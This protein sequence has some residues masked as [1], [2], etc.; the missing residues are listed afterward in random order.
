MSKN[1]KG[2]IYRRSLRSNNTGQTVCNYLLDT[3]ELRGCPVDNC[4]K[5]LTE[6]DIKMAHKRLTPEQKAGIV[7][8]RFE[9]GMTVTAIAAKYGICRSTAFNVISEY[10]NHGYTLPDS[11]PE[12]A[13][14]TDEETE[15]ATDDEPCY[16]VTGDTDIDAYMADR[17]VK[18][19]AS[20]ATETSSEQGSCKDDPENIIPQEAE[21]VK[22]EIL[23]DAVVRA[24]VDA[25]E[26]LNKRIPQIEEQTE[27]MLRARGRLYTDRAQMR[28]YL[29]EHGYRN[30]LIV[31]EED[32]D[33][34]RKT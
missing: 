30:V 31:L 20:A 5:K 12:T 21:N 10:K 34:H 7:R 24:V 27:A 25:I 16:E 6:E 2:C 28:R 19:P 13:Y 17:K 33:G 23:P 22:R 29:I 8:L 3:G 11:N 14:A 4:D 9:E 18:E 1:C 32:N 26:D 15:R